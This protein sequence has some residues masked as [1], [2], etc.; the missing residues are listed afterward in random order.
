[1]EETILFIRTDLPEPVVPAIRTWGILEISVTTAWP[2]TSSPRETTVL[3]LMFCRLGLGAFHAKLQTLENDWEFRYN[4]VSAGNRA[5]IR[6]WPGGAERARARSEPRAII[7]SL[8]PMAMA[9]AVL[10]TAGPL[11]TSVT[12]AWIPKEPRVFWIISIFLLM[13]LGRLYQVLGWEKIEGGFCQTP[14]RR[15]RS[16]SSWKTGYLRNLGFFDKNF[17]KI[18]AVMLSRL[19]RI[20]IFSTGNFDSAGLVKKSI[21]FTGKR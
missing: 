18:K 3:D 12:L 17:G 19:R 11:W 20:Y 1:M 10:V 5:S 8:V 21:G 6:I 7:L 2:E 15:G 4:K 13:S 16:A 14:G 9:K